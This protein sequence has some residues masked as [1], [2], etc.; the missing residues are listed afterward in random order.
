MPARL[1]LCP[2]N[3]LI[4]EPEV[5]FGH[6]KNGNSRDDW[7]AK[8]LWDVR[9]NDKTALAALHKIAEQLKAGD[10]SSATGYLP[11]VHHHVQSS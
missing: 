8:V 2:S 5:L 7:E 9:F 6:I 11:I 4:P 3:R 1:V 10:T